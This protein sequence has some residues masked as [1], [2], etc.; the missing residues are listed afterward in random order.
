MIPARPISAYNQGFHPSKECWKA[1]KLTQQFFGIF[2]KDIFKLKL[3]M[4]KSKL[5]RFAWYI[6]RE[7]EGFRTQ[8]H[9]PFL[10]FS[11]TNR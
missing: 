7:I 4:I 10:V 9:Q 5:N 8:F 2:S 6:T 11:I 3:S 1:P